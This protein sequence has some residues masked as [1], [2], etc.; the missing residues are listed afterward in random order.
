MKLNSILNNSQ[1]R[2]GIDEN[3]HLKPL[4]TAVLIFFVYSMLISVYIWLSGKVAANIATSVAGLEH[5]EF[6]KGIVFV[7]VTGAALFVC[8]FTTLRKIEQ[9]DNIIIA[10]NKSLIASERLV[11]AGLFSSSVCHDINNLM[12]I[13]I[14]QTD[15]LG[16]SQNLSAA[17]RESVRKILLTSQK[18]T[19]LVN[20]MMA[21]GKGY[22]PGAKTAGD[23]ANVIRETIAFAQI[24]KKIKRC[25]V[26][27]DVPESVEGDFNATLL[28]RA[29]MN[30]L[31]NAAE[32][33]Q[34]QGEIFVR[35]T[36]KDGLLSI[37]VHDNGQ[38]IPDTMKDRI[39]EPFFTSKDEGTGLGLLS[40]KICAEQHQGVINLRKS[41][42]GGS[43]F[44]L[45]FS[46]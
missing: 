20:R 34:E 18:L 28:S 4:R 22:I 37:E 7:F 8:A 12:T 10:Q 36:E 11:M 9:K 16:M 26:Y 17:D 43:C 23:I 27:Y 41:H 2:V 30:L 6:S 46:V 35:L 32:A 21:A 38:E 44:C 5:I 1:F 42:L 40:L 33:T 39:F 19:S 45:T 29:L 15:V 24:H 25:H 3:S 14:G 13:V 31:L